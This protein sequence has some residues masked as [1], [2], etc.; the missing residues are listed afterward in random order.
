MNLEEYKSQAAQQYPNTAFVEETLRNLKNNRSKLRVPVK[1]IGKAVG[2]ISLLTA[3]AFAIL[4]G[5]GTIRSTLS[6]V[7]ITEQNPEEEQA[8]LSD[9]EAL[10]MTPLS[11]PDHT[12]RISTENGKVAMNENTT[13]EEIIA[14][15]GVI[16]DG[17]GFVGYEQICN[18]FRA[19]RNGEAAELVIAEPPTEYR[20]DRRAYQYIGLN[21]DGTVNG[22]YY[23]HEGEHL[24]T[25]PFERAGVGSRTS[26]GIRFGYCA[27]TSSSEYNKYTGI[28][29]ES[30][31]TVAGMAI[32]LSSYGRGGSSYNPPA[33]N[34]IP[35]CTI[36]DLL[37][38]AERDGDTIREEYFD[39]LSNLGEKE[40]VNIL[41]NG[42]YST[43]AQLELFLTRAETDSVS[44]CSTTITDLTKTDEYEECF[45]AL[46]YLDGKYRIFSMKN[47]FEGEF[48]TELFDG[49]TVEDGTLIFS[50]GSAEYRFPYVEGA[51]DELFVSV[52]PVEK[53]Y[54]GND[55]G[56]YYTPNGLANGGNW[57]VRYSYSSAINWQ[58]VVYS[59]EGGFTVYDTGNPEPPRFEPLA[60]D[61]TEVARFA[62]D[63]RNLM[64]ISEEYSEGELLAVEILDQNET[65]SVWDYAIIDI[66][67]AL[68]E[69]TGK[70]EVSENTNLWLNAETCDIREMP[71]GKSYL[72]IT[73][74]QWREFTIKA[75]TLDAENQRLSFFAYNY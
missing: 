13:A 58:A 62:A 66:T 31:S 17:S 6:E 72:M 56:T 49:Y 4:V 75:S 65:P 50:N 60:V 39:V 74:E 35:I 73:E 37:N 71:D 20:P 46:E 70:I 59:N 1:K 15:G 7:S 11:N 48:H 38:V 26:Y 42:Q 5:V 54:I 25:F 43:P 33:R 18:F 10:Y 61:P 45:Y 44:Y 27:A 21:E 64:K 12:V 14:C 8:N 69:K 22:K 16:D 51:L 68:P 55:A 47:G 9:R 57:Y 52:S 32:D 36:T 19:Y 34:F 53:R 2:G 28:Q 30:R 67:L 29:P 24:S 40:G 41:W 3:A 63:P 23:L